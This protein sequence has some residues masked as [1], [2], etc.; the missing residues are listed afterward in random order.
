MAPPKVSPS[1]A[2][3]LLRD[4]RD[5]RK[6][7]EAWN[8]GSEHTTGFACPSTDSTAGAGPLSDEDLPPE[9]RQAGQ[10]MP[11]HSEGQMEPGSPDSDSASQVSSR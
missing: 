3:P 11:G 6:L 9:H 4:S 2:D 1:S 7:A 10:D 5:Y 8:V